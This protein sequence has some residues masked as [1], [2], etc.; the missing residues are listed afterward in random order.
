MCGCADLPVSLLADE[1]GDCQRD[2]TAPHSRGVPG[3]GGQRKRVEAGGCSA[4]FVRRLI[5][6]WV[7]LC[8]STL[9]TKRVVAGL[10]PTTTSPPHVCTATPTF[11][12]MLCVAQVLGDTRA[13]FDI[14]EH[15]TLIFGAHGILVAGPNSRHHEPLLCSYL[16]VGS[17]VSRFTGSLTTVPPTLACLGLLPMF[18]A[19]V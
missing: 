5:D 2:H 19:A 7:A 8:S 17:G 9:A 3:Q 14:S 15:D 16:Q 10:C 11:P 6:T 4:L 18:T 1:L 13:A 12:W